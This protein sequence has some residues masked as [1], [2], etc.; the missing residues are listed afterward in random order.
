[1]TA[2]SITMNRHSIAQIIF[3]T[4]MII[5]TVSSCKKP[6]DVIDA[7]NSNQPFSYSSDVLDKWMT[8]ELRLMRNAVGIPNQAFS[9][10]L[11]Y[12]GIAAIESIGPGIPEHKYWSSKWNG[13][14]GLPAA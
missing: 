2:T 12:A 5:F 7:S 8:M 6:A 14:T 11:V 1:M 10:H 4:L 3:V 13:L 9:R